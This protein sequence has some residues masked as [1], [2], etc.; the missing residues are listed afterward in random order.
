MSHSSFMKRCLELAEKA[1][2]RVAPNPM[3]GCVIVHEGKVIGEGYHEEY[4]QAHAEVNA[5]G[6]VKDKGL[7][8]RSTLY[9]NLE[10]CAHYGKTPPCADLI[11]THKIPYVV[12]GTI[13]P[14]AAVKGKGIEKLARAGVDVKAG[15]L[16]TECRELNRR[17][18]TFHEKQR[19]YIILKWAQ[20]ADHFIAR[21]DKGRPETASYI[22]APET[23]RLVH[24]WR[25]QE[26]GI[27]VGTRTVE[28]DNP[29]LTVRHVSGRNP[30]RIVF[31]RELRLPAGAKIF[32]EAAPT[33]VFNAQRSGRRGNAELIACYELPAV[34]KELHARSIQSVIV[35]G[36]TRLIR[37]FV[38]LG[39]W[40][41][42]R[43]LT[44]PLKFGTGV[45]AP[46]PAGKPA[47][48]ETMG[49]DRIAIYR[50]V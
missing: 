44:S 36:G 19:P 27:M 29:A 28:A 4:G 37:S 38:E 48:Q 46:F 15:V 17:F 20:T 11:L 18:F 31:D 41:E 33:L 45:P 8:G 24:Q 1:I 50:N 10:P 13:D 25:S 40:D 32:D 26:A 9:V 16:E 34:M 35:E 3:V 47:R 43:V 12:I 5:I 22:S 21:L 30:V 7:L 2:G 49:P 14:F 42:M 6:S 39:L 23:L